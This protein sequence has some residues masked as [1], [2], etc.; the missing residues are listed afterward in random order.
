MIINLTGSHQFKLKLCDGK[1]VS[2]CL[3]YGMDSRKQFVKINSN[4]MVVNSKN[5]STL[6][7][8]YT[9]LCKDINDLHSLCWEV[10]P[11]SYDNSLQNTIPVCKV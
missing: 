4:I 9:C 11:F 5:K 3:S 2:H 6:Y 7:D 8:I 10:Q 1:P